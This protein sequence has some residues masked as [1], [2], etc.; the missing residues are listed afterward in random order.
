MDLHIKNNILHDASTNKPKRALGCSP[1]V[2]KDRKKHYHRT[3]IFG[4]YPYLAHL[5]LNMQ[6]AKICDQ[7]IQF[8]FHLHNKQ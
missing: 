2:Y 8:L 5:V 7:E 6:I 3:L 1:T 4:R